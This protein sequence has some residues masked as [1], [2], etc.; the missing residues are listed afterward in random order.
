MSN[1]RIP[2]REF[3]WRG[4][5]LHLGRRKKPVLTLVP[6]TAY[7]HLYRIRYPNGWTSAPA[8]ITRAKDAAYSHARYLLVTE[9]GVSAPHSPE[10]GELAA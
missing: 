6:E 9:S 2:R 3:V 8:N 4:L 7:P 1:D 10:A 5:G